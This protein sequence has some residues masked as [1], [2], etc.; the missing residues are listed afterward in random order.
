MVG[1]RAC[2][3]E[4][5]GSIP[6][7]ARLRN[8]SRQVVHTRLPRRRQSSLLYGAIKPGAF[9]FKTYISTLKTITQQGSH[10]PQTP[11]LLLPPN[12]TAK[13]GPVRPSPT[14]GIPT[15]RL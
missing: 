2:E 13:S 14:T 12:P 10:R 5:A 1:R 7:R 9:T 11:P 3:Q 6:V 15:R 8:D 4:V